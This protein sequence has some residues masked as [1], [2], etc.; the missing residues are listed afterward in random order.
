VK[1]GYP[2][3]IVGDMGEDIGLEGVSVSGLVLEP[4]STRNDAR[5]GFGNGL[6]AGGDSSVGRA[7]GKL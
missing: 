3:S 7:M 5:L 4:I 2:G 1:R 6:L